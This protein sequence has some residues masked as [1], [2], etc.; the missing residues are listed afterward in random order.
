MKPANVILTAEKQVKLIDFGTMMRADPTEETSRQAIGTR[1]YAA[2]EQY[3]WAAAVDVRTDVY[4]VGTTLYFLTTGASPDALFALGPKVTDAETIHFKALEDI[5]RKCMEQDPYKRYQTCIELI[6]DLKIFM[7]DHEKKLRIQNEPINRVQAVMPAVFHFSIPKGSGVILTRIRQQTEKGAV[8]IAK[9]VDEYC[10]GGPR[11]TKI[12]YAG[13]ELVFQ[14]AYDRP[15]VDQ[16]F[17]FRN[18]LKETVARILI[19]PWDNEAY[20]EYDGRR[21]FV[22]WKF[23]KPPVVQFDPDTEWGE[24]C[25]ELRPTAG[26]RM[27]EDR[28]LYHYETVINGHLPE[29]LVMILL[30]L[31]FTGGWG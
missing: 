30:S 2:P 22:K 5:I 17:E 28:D 11:E 24:G 9:V 3:D 21:I 6:A 4:G 19:I 12:I 23:R 31:I 18:E 16:R 20:V 7:E 10:V 15:M 27:T 14:T 26:Y 8:C 29:P 1:G 25:E 13:G